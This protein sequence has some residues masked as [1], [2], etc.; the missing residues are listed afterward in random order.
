MLSLFSSTLLFAQYVVYEPLPPAGKTNYSRHVEDGVYNATVY[1]MNVGNSYS[2]KYTLKVSVSY[3]RVTKIDFGNGGN[4]H[5]GFNN[6]GYTYSGGE[7]TYKR[8][9]NYDIVS[10]TASVTIMDPDI[11]IKRFTIVIQ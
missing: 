9:N 7:L 6:E 8:D 2:A 11:K 3:G 5:T 10:G 1:Y 4:V